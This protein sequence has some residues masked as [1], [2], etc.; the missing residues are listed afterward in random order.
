MV[1]QMKQDN[2]R[3]R[4]PVPTLAEVSLKRRRPGL[5]HT[6]ESQGNEPEFVREE[7][8]GNTKLELLLE[9]ARLKREM[10]LQKVSHRRQLSN[11][12]QEMLVN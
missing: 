3:K 5:V 7:D 1:E 11:L 6:Q 2:A 12:N 9:R 8:V 10:E 4:K